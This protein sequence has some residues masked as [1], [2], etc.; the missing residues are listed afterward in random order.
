MF[1]RQGGTAAIAAPVM[2]PIADTAVASFGDTIAVEIGNV[3]AYD[4]GTKVRLT[5]LENFVMLIR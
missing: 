3:V 5:F 1:Y 4:V 2:G